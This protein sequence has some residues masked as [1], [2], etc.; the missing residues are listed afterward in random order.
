MSKMITKRFETPDEVRDVPKA[1]V[2]V[3]KLGDA[4]AMR[5]TFEP[6]WKW[7]ESV[8]PVVGTD[9]CETEHLGYVISGTMVCRMKDG[10]ELTFKSGDA[11]IIPPG[12]DAWSRAASPAFFSTSRARPVTPSLMNRKPPPSSANMRPQTSP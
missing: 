4:T 3:V 1:R 6:G 7:S 2:E 5:G 12:H 8:K 9:L 10:T 11:A